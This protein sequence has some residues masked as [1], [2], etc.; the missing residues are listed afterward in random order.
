VFNKIAAVVM[1]VCGLITLSMLQGLFA[2]DAITQMMFQLD[3]DGPF[4]AIIVPNWSVL[5]GLGGAMLIFGAFN[6][7][8]RR[9]CLAIP[10]L[11]KLSFLILAFT[12]GQAYFDMMIVPIIVDSVMVTLF[13]IFLIT[14]FVRAP[15]PSV[16]AA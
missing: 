1:V 6:P 11:S 15:A 10:G 5:V 2:P 7:Q 14:G 3:A 16:A 8:S 9:L 12:Q 4:R 13:A